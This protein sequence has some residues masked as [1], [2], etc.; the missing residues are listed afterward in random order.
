MSDLPAKAAQ[1]LKEFLTTLEAWNK[2]DPPIFVD[3]TGWLSM[4]SNDR[5][6]VGFANDAAKQIL[7]SS[8]KDDM[9]GCLLC[10]S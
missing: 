8:G 5:S 3:D 7:E 2:E 6:I 1:Q 9:G 4:S 10:C